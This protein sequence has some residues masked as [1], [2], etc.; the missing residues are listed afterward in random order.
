MHVRLAHGFVF[1]KDLERAVH[2]YEQALGMRPERTSHEDYVVMTFGEGGAGVALHR[3]PEYLRD[4]IVILDPPEW[5][6][7]TAYKLTFATD[8]LPGLREAILAAGGRAADPWTWDGKTFCECTDP[9]GN[10]VQIVTG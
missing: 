7:E 8:D 9:E 3:L 2:F 10:V 5:R 1:V 4:Q 6:D